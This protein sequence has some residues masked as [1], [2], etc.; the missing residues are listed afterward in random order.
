MPSNRLSVRTAR[1]INILTI[2]Y[3]INVTVDA[4]QNSHP[5]LK[6]N[7]IIF[8]DHNTV[9]NGITYHNFTVTGNS[10]R[11][12]TSVGNADTLLAC[13]I[14]KIN[15][16][17]EEI[18]KWSKLNFG[19]IRFGSKLF[20]LRGGYLGLRGGYL[21]LH[22]SYLG[23]DSSYLRLDSSYIR[24]SSSYIR[25][26]SSRKLRLS[27]CG[28]GRTRGSLVLTCDNHKKQCKS[29]HSDQKKFFHDF[30]SFLKI[31]ILY[32]QSFFL[33]VHATVANA[34]ITTASK[35]MTEEHPDPVD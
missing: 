1:S 26:D 25:F 10:R 35:P 5:T 17:V 32:N 34:R 2:V 14:N 13:T 23:L 30:V 12:K 8:V 19:I 15:V 24:L 28:F 9:I 31:I 7:S 33:R 22:S 27:R 6:V 18:F 3:T 11:A 16:G 20:G 4:A 21:R 29:Q